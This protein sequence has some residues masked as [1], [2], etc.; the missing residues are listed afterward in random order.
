MFEHLL[1]NCFLVSYTKDASKL[2]TVCS[3]GV[4]QYPAL[5]TLSLTC[6]YLIYG[7]CDT[8]ICLQTTSITPGVDVTLLTNAILK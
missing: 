3:V 7:S 4:T 5:D 6:S 1:S 8:Y 2:V